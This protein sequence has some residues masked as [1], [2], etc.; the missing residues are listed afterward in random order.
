M[1]EMFPYDGEEADLRDFLEDVFNK[2]T[3]Q[4]DFQ[5]VLK[6]VFNHTQ[7]VTDRDAVDRIDQVSVD[8][9]TN[10]NSRIK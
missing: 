3:T 8:M 9:K 10:Y 4:M 5:D 1:S 2:N 7:L 6:N